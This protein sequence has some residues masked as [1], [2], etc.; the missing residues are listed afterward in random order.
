ML[1]ISAS[2][3]IADRSQNLGELREDICGIVVSCS[4]ADLQ[5][6][7][8]TARVDVAVSVGVIIRRKHAPLRMVMV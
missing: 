5:F 4:C 8:V 6:N 3:F 1:Q 2:A 7:A